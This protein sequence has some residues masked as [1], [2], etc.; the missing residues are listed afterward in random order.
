VSREP[1]EG[2]EVEEDPAPRASPLRI[3]AT[4]VL[5]GFVLS[6]LVPLTQLLGAD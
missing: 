1:D 6:I 4:L 3:V 5:L 2:S